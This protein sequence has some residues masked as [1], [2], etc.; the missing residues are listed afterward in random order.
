MNVLLVIPKFGDVENTEAFIP[1][2]TAYIN[3]A[4]RR[5]GFNA[6]SYTHLDVYKRQVAIVFKSFSPLSSSITNSDLNLAER[7]LLVRDI[8]ICN[9]FFS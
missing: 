1:I 7:F 4:I 2:G 6:V 9:T 5:A 8:Y 3:A